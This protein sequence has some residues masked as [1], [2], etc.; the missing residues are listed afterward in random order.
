MVL[1]QANS[2]KVL[3]TSEKGG[4]EHGGFKVRINQGLTNGHYSSSEGF[5]FFGR[6]LFA[7]T[8]GGATTLIQ[9]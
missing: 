3:D 7:R 2:K 1:P 5:C 4:E 9:S 6:P 8:S